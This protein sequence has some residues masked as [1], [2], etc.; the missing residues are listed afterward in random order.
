MLGLFTMKVIQPGEHDH[1]HRPRRK[2]LRTIAVLPTLLT[3]GNMLCGF[4][5]IYFCMLGLF[6]ATV[7]P[8]GRPAFRNRF[9]EG[10]L[11]NPVVEHFLPTC[12]SVGGFLIFLGLIFDMMDGRVAR[13]TR[14]TT[15][16]GG[17][18]DSLADIV[19]F[20]IAPAM[21]MIGLVTLEANPDPGVTM[22][23]SRGAW[24]CGA[25]FAACAALRL[26][27]FNVEHADSGT[28][29]SSFRGLPSPGAGAGLAS[30][31]VLYEHVPEVR[32]A[33]LIKALPYIALVT[34]LLMISRIR[35]VHVAN[36]YL[37]GRRPFSYVI[38]ILVVLGLLIRYPGQ[39]LAGLVGA[40]AVSGPIAALWRFVRLRAAAISAG[41]ASHAQTTKPPEEK[42]A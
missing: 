39:M 20:G 28:K 5:A 10:L 22:M 7:A 33:V 32:A 8:D 14:Q 16:F 17:Q 34:G 12:I 1:R 21:L 18:L 19:T 38:L 15:N 9:V 24:M 37:R 6:A 3:L 23:T 4:S 27:R 29:Y 2:R 36:T 40:Y 31:I 42:T 25:I 26:A 11:S 41:Q 13:I 35:Y 30:F